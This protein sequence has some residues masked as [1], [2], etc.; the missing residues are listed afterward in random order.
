MF[1][2]KDLSKSN[3]YTVGYNAVFINDGKEE[4]MLWGNSLHIKLN[5][6][7]KGLQN[8]ISVKQK[9]I[10]AQVKKEIGRTCKKC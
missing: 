10:K 8:L 3:I 1:K 4:L 6:G 7:E 5:G 9:V 2:S